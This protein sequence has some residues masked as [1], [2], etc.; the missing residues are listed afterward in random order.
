MLI[1]V[2]LGDSPH[3]RFGDGL[4]LLGIAPEEI[5]PKPIELICG[6]ERGGGE[7]RLQG[8]L[9]IPDKVVLGPGKL[10]GSLSPRPGFAA[11]PS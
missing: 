9:E 10:I 3:V 2:G 6:H 11:A 4:Y 1:E 8:K 7:V 5:I